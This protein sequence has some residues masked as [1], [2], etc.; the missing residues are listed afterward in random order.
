MPLIQTEINPELQKLN[1]ESAWVELYTLDASASGGAIYHFCNHL[2]QSGGNVVFGSTVYNALPIKVSGWNQ[3]QTG[4]S[5]KPEVTLSN[6]SKAL[7]S[8]VISQ[9]DLVGAKLIR[10]RTF[11]KFL[12]DGASP[13]GG[14]YVG[15]DTMVIEQKTHHDRSTIQFQ[16]TSVLDRLGMKLPRRQV[17]KDANH[18]GCAFPGVSRNRAS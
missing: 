1:Q 3:T 15:P 4:T 14:A 18:L 7:L 13:N 16:L 8:A 12:A 6:L 2:N 9:G 10:I 11:S 5:P 17:L